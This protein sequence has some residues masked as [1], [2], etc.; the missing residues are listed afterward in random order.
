MGA[1]NQIAPAFATKGPV[2]QQQQQQLQ[3]QQHQQHPP[4]DDNVPK[5]QGPISFK[6]ALLGEIEVLEG[7]DVAKVVERKTRTLRK[8][9]RRQVE[10]YFGEKN[11]RTDEHIRENTDTSGFVHLDIIMKFERL[12]ALTEDVSFVRGCLEGSDIV[13]VSESGL[14]V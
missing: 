4:M 9:V 7:E 13:E 11:W 3:P 12:R 2:L 1:G 5:G 8:A 10:Y 14:L 6:H